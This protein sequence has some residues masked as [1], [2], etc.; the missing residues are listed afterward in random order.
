[1]KVKYNLV[2]KDTTTILIMTL[3]LT[4]LLITLIITLNRGNITYNYITC[5]LFYL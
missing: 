2:F 5:N 1:M 3:F 4:T